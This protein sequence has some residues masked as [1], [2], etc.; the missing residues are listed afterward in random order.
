[1]KLDKTLE[2]AYTKAFRA[3]KVSYI[4]EQGARD[5]LDHDSGVAEELKK[6]LANDPEFAASP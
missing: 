2:N 6:R 1:V 3:T 5:M 4:A